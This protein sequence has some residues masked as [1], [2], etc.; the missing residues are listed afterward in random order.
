MLCPKKNNLLCYTMDNIKEPFVNDQEC[1]EPKVAE[2][3]PN[4]SPSHVGTVVPAVKSFIARINVD[5]ALI[6]LQIVGVSV[7]VSILG[8]FLYYV[9]AK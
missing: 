8:L 4:E 5:D 9:V 7:G 3:P 2:S 6:V 1:R